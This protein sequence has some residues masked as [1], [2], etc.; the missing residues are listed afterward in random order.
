[1]N[2][3]LDALRAYPFERLAA[4]KAGI[5]APP[6]YPEVMLSIGEPK[7]APPEFVL[8]LLTDRDLLA[9]DLAGYPATR[10]SPELRAA[11]AAWIRSLNAAWGNCRWM[12]RGCW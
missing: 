1:V 2:P 8:D 5:V 7:H 3:Q 11:I 9:R 6:G 10:G 4:L 12:G